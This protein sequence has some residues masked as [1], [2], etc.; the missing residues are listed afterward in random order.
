MKRI[1][2]ALVLFAT[3]S[4]RADDLSPHLKRLQET[5]AAATQLIDI[6][7]ETI[8]DDANTMAKLLRLNNKEINYIIY[9][10]VKL[11]S[12][13]VKRIQAIQ[14]QLTK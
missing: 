10:H 4:L 9:P 1:I 3:F 8:E 7:S 13:S 12:H 2:I 11:L 6:Q 14:K 5:I